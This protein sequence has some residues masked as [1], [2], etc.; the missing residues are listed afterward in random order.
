[1]SAAIIDRG[2][3]PEIAGTRI[4]VYDIWDY[5]R[6]GHHHTYIA[7]VLGVSSA[8]VIAGLEYIDAHKPRVLAEYEKILARV[9]RGN[10]PE[11]EAKLVESR[12]KLQALRENLRHEKVPGGNHEGNPAGQ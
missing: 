11:I 5:A 8:Q 12:A 7:A 6:V 4:T 10:A 1:M 9:N 3:G 2:R